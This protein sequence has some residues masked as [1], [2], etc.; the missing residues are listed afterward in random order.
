MYGL[1]FEPPLLALLPRMQSRHR[2][3]T[4]GA[5]L[6][7]VG[8]LLYRRFALFLGEGGPQG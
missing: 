6:F 8:P 1:R 7:L 2:K 5:G 4:V 3:F